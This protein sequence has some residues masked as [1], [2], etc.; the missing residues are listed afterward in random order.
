[1]SPD[2]PLDEV[3]ERAERA[4]AELKERVAELD[5]LQSAISRVTGNDGSL[6]DLDALDDLDLAEAQRRAAEYED[7]ITWN[8]TCTS[9]A[10][11]LDSLIKETERAEKAEAALKRD[12]TGDA[13]ADTVTVPRP[14]VPYGPKDVDPDRADAA[15]LRQAAHNIEWARCLG[16]NLTRV[17]VK[18]LDDV[19]DRIA[20]T[21]QTEAA[22]DVQR[23]IRISG[24]QS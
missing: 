15:Y 17:V 2:T 10:A 1:M 5:A 3:D 20:A 13:L 19:A 23:A 7:A 4:E 18:L 21:R 8:T 6:S 11:V 22:L 12:G 24:E 14:R 9:C 16:S